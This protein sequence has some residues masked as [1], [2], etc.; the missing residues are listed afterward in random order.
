MWNK[1][2]RGYRQFKEDEP[3]ARFLNTYQRSREHSKGPAATILIIVAGALLIVGGFFLG[4]VPGVPGIVLGLL[5]FALIATRFR[6]MAK[7]LDWTEVKVRR[8]WQRW[9]RVMAH[10]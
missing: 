9:R 1:L 6:R 8:I 4:L 5:G 10:R 3:G 2:K 7:W